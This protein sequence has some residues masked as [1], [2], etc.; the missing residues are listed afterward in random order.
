MAQN[1]T[2]RSVAIELLRTGMIY[3]YNLSP[4]IKYLALCGTNPKVDFSIELTQSEFNKCVRSLRYRGVDKG[5]AAAAQEQLEKVVRGIFEKL[6]YLKTE[7]GGADWLH[8]RLRVTPKELGLLP[9][10]FSLTPDYF[11]E[12]R[13]ESFLLNPSRRTTL[14]REVRQATPHAFTWP[15]SPRVLFAWSERGGKVPH[16]AHGLALAQALTPW[17]R[18][19]PKNP[20]PVPDLR[21]L[22][23]EL[24]DASP[25]DI[26]EEFRRVLPKRPYT[27]VHLLAHGT[28]VRDEGD[29]SEQFALSLNKR[30]APGEKD[31][32]D[33]RRLAEALRSGEGAEAV[34]PGV[35]VISAC[36]GGNEGDVITPGAS[37]AHALHESGIPYVLASQFPLT[38]PGSVTMAKELYPLLFRGE[39]PR[40]ALHH[41]RRSLK[42]EPQTKETHDWASLVA[43]ARFPEDLGRQLSWVR[44]D[45]VLREMKAVNVLADH[46]MKYREKVETTF[47]SVGARLDE[48]IKELERLLEEGTPDA[49]NPRCMAEHMGLLGSAYKRKA[50][51]LYRQA[52]LQKE[53]GAAAGLRQKSAQALE[54]SRE[55]YLKGQDSQFFDHWTGCQY[56][57][58]AAVTKGTL[59]DDADL[60]QVIRFSAVKALKDK[61]ERVWALGTM[62]E[63]H[64][65]KPLTFPPERFDEVRRAALEEARGYLTEF[66]EVAPPDEKDSTARQ[67][68]RY[69]K[70]WPD[71]F[72]TDG[73]KRLKD[74]AAELRPLLPPLEECAV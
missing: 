42:S 34:R 4:D 56:L 52:A 36:D 22:F 58:L 5:S 13:G 40:C 44:L 45:A 39:D 47:E 69:I 2:S 15:R 3:N 68:E 33:G 30:G 19:L 48:S 41:L 55:W 66:K 16:H 43:Y 49:D 28:A 46:V 31:V 18:P 73:M 17:A 62:T 54:N 65:L 21:E 25:E 23:T 10:E 71:A 50:E 27:H 6:S 32:V 24:P 37:L 61:K 51:N 35:V 11:E 57:S 26:A 59:A 20:E 7:A 64:L 12:G 8:L 67:L 53:P 60:W 1:L 70:W 38:E 9:F 74:M 63:L 29:G 72:P 14:T